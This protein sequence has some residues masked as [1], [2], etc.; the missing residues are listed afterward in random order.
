M[1]T[2]DKIIEYLNVHGSGTV[3]LMSRSIGVTKADV[4]YQLRKLVS[5]DL[6]FVTNNRYQNG[7]GRPAA[8]FSLHERIPEKFF[9]TL[10]SGLLNYLFSDCSQVSQQN[11]QISNLV[12]KR[13]LEGIPQ[14]GS[15]A[16]GLS[17]KID[18]LRQFGFEIEWIAGPHGPVFHITREPLTTSIQNPELSSRI[19]QVLLERL[20]EK[21]PG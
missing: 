5:S 2:R 3:N 14:S 7:R 10:I 11:D 8:T 16:V 12:V 17:R 18:R 4:R 15:P 13:M 6:V 1:N 9:S 20:N 21:S 19:M